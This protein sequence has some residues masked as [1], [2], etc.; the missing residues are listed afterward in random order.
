MSFSHWLIDTGVSPPLTTDSKV[1]THGIPNK[2]LDFLHV[3]TKKTLLNSSVDDPLQPFLPPVRG[4]GL[5]K[6]MEMEGS[7]SVALALFNSEPQL[8]ELNQGY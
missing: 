1:M 6:L 7:A 8:M 5:A 3:F 4:A 2:P